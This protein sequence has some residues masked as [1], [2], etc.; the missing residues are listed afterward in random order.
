MPE[1][2]RWVIPEASMQHDR[3]F[4]ALIEHSSDAVA[5]LTQEGIFTYASPSSH[6]VTGYPA[7]ELI[8]TNAFALLHPDDLASVQ[9]RVGVL[10]ERPGDFVTIAYGCAT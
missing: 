3:R 2:E 10:L 1:R 9:Q 7:E 6:R 8:G 4:R 5:L